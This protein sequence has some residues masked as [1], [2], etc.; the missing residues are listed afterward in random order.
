MKLLRFLTIS[1]T[2]L[3]L[4]YPATHFAPPSSEMTAIQ[5]TND[6][7]SLIGKT[8]RWKAVDGS[9][10]G[11]TFEH[12]LH[13]D[14]TITWRALDGAYKGASRRE[15]PYM[16]LKVGERVW[17]ISYLAASGHTLTVLLN[18]DDNRTTFFGSNEK[19][20]EMSHGTFDFVHTPEK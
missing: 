2:L 20:W 1:A 17:A 11:I 6:M 12:E 18:L 10:A 8:I 14:G 3:A 19:S 5:E 9:T 4:P 15:K 7:D 13:Q 16:A